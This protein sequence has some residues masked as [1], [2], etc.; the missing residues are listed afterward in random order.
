MEQILETAKKILKLA[1]RGA[2]EHEKGAARQK[3]NDL[4]QKHNL[5]LADLSEIKRDWVKFIPR[6]DFEHTILFQCAFKVLNVEKINYRQAGKN[7]SLYLELTPAEEADIKML[8]LYYRAIWKKEVQ[9]FLVAFMAKH[10][11]HGE[12]SK[13]SDKPMDFERLERLMN[14]MAGIKSAPNPLKVRAL[15]EP[16]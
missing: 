5:K 15:P 14:M 1:E 7:K 13:G 12:S 8:F 16:I 6:D 4:L 9:D 11:L 10:K 3:L 2:T